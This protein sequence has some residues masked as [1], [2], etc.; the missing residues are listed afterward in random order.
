MDELS[1]E[2]LRQKYKTKGY[3]SHLE[4]KIK[5]N[6]RDY[7]LPDI[8]GE[9]LSEMGNK[10]YELVQ[11]LPE[12]RENQSRQGIFSNPPSEIVT[13]TYYFKRWFKYGS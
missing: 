1:E 11:I 5:A 13:Y 10:G 12:W 2:E 7:G 8:E 4:R 3:W 6:E 9:L